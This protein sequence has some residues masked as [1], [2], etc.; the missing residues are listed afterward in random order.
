MN[1][2]KPTVYISTKATDLTN[3]CNVAAT[4]F[5]HHSHQAGQQ[6]WNADPDDWMITAE[7]YVNLKSHDLYGTRWEPARLE[8]MPLSPFDQGLEPVPSSWHHL[9]PVNLP[10]TEAGGALAKIKRFLGIR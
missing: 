5:D 4:L 6:V 2:N 8:H 10:V 1:T 7:A 3:Q 9:F